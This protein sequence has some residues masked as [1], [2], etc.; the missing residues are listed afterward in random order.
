[1]SKTCQASVKAKVGSES[2]EYRIV[3]QWEFYSLSPARQ[4]MIKGSVMSPLLIVQPHIFYCNSF[5]WPSLSS[6]KWAASPWAA[7]KTYIFLANDVSPRVPGLFSH[8]MKFIYGRG[9][10]QSVC[11]K[12]RQTRCWF[13]YSLWTDKP[14]IAR[15]VCFS[16][17]PYKDHFACKFCLSLRIG[18]RPNLCFRIWG[19]TS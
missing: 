12:W 16:Q 1:M 14:S 9:H 3:E 13:F 18:V 4:V 15:E 6:F 8:L 7:A 19:S 17:L 10:G 5:V 11:C 2:D